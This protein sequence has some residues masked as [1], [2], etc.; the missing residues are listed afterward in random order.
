MSDGDDLG[1]QLAQMAIDASY[2]EFGEDAIY[3]PPPGQAG[4]DIDCRVIIN[5]EDRDLNFGDTRALA[6]GNVIEVRA[7]EVASPVKAGV[8]LIGD[9]A[10]AIASQPKSEDPERLTFTMSAVPIAA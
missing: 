7:S 4:A 10:Y 9:E 8:F 6:R 2:A 3:R 5:S 1:L